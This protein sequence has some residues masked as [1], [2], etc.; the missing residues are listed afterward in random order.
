MAAKENK[1]AVD[2]AARKFRVLVGDQDAADAKPE[3]AT[4]NPPKPM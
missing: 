4:R 3:D 2:E 1:E